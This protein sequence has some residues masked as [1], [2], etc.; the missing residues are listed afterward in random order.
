LVLIASG[1][2]LF[3]F[4]GSA[5]VSAQGPP[6]FPLQPTWFNVVDTYWGSSDDKVNAAPGDTNIPFT[7]TIQNISNSTVTGISET[8][9]LQRPFTNMSGGVLANSFYEG[10]ISPGSTG[11]VQ[12]ILNI[13][14]DAAPGEYVLTMLIDYLTVASG[15]GS[16]LYIAREAE[17]EVPLLIASTHYVTIYSVNVLP[18]EIQPA[19]NITVSGNVVDTATSKTFYN[20]NVS[21]S[22]PAFAKS[23]F[24]F[25][26]Q[27]DPNI[28]RPFSATFQVQ[29]GLPNGT[30]PIK[31]LVTYQDTSNINHAS[32]TVVNLRVQRQTST[33]S[34]RRSETRGPIEILVDFLLRIFQF[35]FGSYTMVLKEYLVECI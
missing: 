24:I 23:T 26:G 20:T 6:Y 33:P 22:S 30:Y 34:V 1:S 10:S 3:L 14:G 28:P 18:R 32:S 29:K 2:L 27:I 31:I 5:K 11:S 9:I 19:G 15:V 16:T 25:I 13:D 7:V 12:F 8:L 35:F 4:D 17:V 21:I